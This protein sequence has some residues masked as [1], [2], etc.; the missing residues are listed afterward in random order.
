M[1][2]LRFLYT[3]LEEVL[4]SIAIS[5]TV[6]VV[7]VN[8]IL[9]YG[10]GFVVPWSEELSVICFIWAVYLGISSGYKHKLHM[11]VD[12]IVS[13]LPERARHLFSIV[14]YGFLL[15]VNGVVGWLSYD[16]MMLSTKITPVIGMPYFYINIVLLISFAM[17][18]IHTLRFLVQEIISLRKLWG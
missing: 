9:R 18:A 11:G 13:Q 10:F 6:L 12:I 15:V 16:Y 17:M 2:V 1:A 14:I 3:Y 4:A 8:V 5:I 7:M